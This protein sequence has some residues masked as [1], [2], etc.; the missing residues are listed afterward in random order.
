MPK[1]IG[2][3]RSGRNIY[4]GFHTKE[5]YKYDDSDKERIRKNEFLIKK[6]LQELYWEIVEDTRK[7]SEEEIITLLSDDRYIFESLEEISR[8]L[9]VIT[10]EINLDDSLKFNSKIRNAISNLHKIINDLNE[11]YIEQMTSIDIEEENG[12]LSSE[13]E[14]DVDI[15]E[16]KKDLI[17]ILE[18]EVARKKE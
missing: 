16:S 13:E 11:G 1:L 2:L 8:E 7:I 5:L 9:K 17:R 10:E 12:F 15:Q 14:L 18:G 4:P 6:W 3:D